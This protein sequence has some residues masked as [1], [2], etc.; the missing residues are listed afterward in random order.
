[1]KSINSSKL[2]H[3][4]RGLSARERQRFLDYVRSPFFNTHPCTCALAQLL[5]EQPAAWDTLTKASLYTALYPSSPYDEAKISNVM[6]YLMKL[7]RGFLTQLGL[8]ASGQ[9]DI[10][11]LQA[12]HQRQLTKL[13]NA[14]LKKTNYDQA[15]PGAW[16]SQQLLNTYQLNLL[17]HKILRQEERRLSDQS[18]Q[19]VLHSLDNW[20]Q[21][22]KL[23]KSC[24]LM[25]L[26]EVGESRA[27]F[28]TD[29]QHQIE[30]SSSDEPPLIS[31]YR[32]CLLTILYPEE[33]LH[34]F[35][36]KKLLIQHTSRLPESDQRDIYR[37]LLN[38]CAKKINQNDLSYRREMFNIY[39]QATASGMVLENGLIYQITYSNIIS[40]ACLLG[41][42]EWAE[43]F[44]E[45]F[46][47]NLLPEARENAYAFS[48]AKISLF[49]GQYQE[50]LSRLGRV[51]FTNFFYQ[52]RSR[53]YQII[54]YYELGQYQ[55]VESSLESLRLYLIR[56]R[57]ATKFRK[58]GNRFIR[59]TKSLVSLRETRNRYSQRV[60]ER[61]IR[62]LKEKITGTSGAI[63][64]YEW[65]L[66]KLNESESVGHT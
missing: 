44:T 17:K 49:K 47:K 59:F 26:T 55:L 41:D 35:T 39:K 13:V 50:A 11:M 42:F 22:I 54:A 29:L 66:K 57:E 25:A 36:L 15:A 9:E 4:L 51:R 7:L 53:L 46:R 10:L 3:N 19:Q 38:Y 5:L 33:P 61:N 63:M 58:S 52:L 31:L 43:N 62:A 32:K 34:Y 60:Y 8:E 21:A 1:M 56:S 12:A 40:L 23:E 64:E 16:G 27:A 65:L 30:R 14:E 28:P 20:Y 2:I 45:N 18:L 37:H 6:S 24:E 48:L